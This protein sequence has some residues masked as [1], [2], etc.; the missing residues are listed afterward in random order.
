MT[1]WGFDLDEILCDFVSG[2]LQHTNDYFGLK[3]TKKDLKKYYMH[4]N[5]AITAEEMNPVNAMVTTPESYLNR[6]LILEGLT[7]FNFIKR[8]GAKIDIVTSRDEKVRNLTESWLKKHG[9]LYD[10]LHMTCHKDK[11]SLAK[12]LGLDYFVEDHPGYA[13][14]I[15]ANGIQVFIPK[16]PWNDGK[17]VHPKARYINGCSELLELIDATGSFLI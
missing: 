15:A 9:I 11:A 16:L 8:T 12:D 14:N 4:E 10:N 7:A 13:A 6:P 17:V 5:L 1:Y 3:L 2:Q